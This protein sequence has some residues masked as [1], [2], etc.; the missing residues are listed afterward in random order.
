LPHLTRLS[1]VARR[2][3]VRPEI[4]GR[5]ARPAGPTDDADAQDASGSR[6]PGRWPGLPDRP[7]PFLLGYVKRRPLQFGVLFSIVVTATCC[8]VGAQYGMKLIVD[9]M[10]TGDRHSTM[11]W[12]W[13]ALFVG[14]IAVES[15]LWRLGGWL[16][17]RTVVGTGVDVRLDLFRHLS[18]HP[19]QYFANHMSGAL[20]SRVTATAGAVGGVFGS[21]TWHI[22]P[23]CI[24]FIGAIVVLFSINNRMALALVCSAAIVAGIITLFGGRGRPLH[25]AYAE[26]ASTV[27]GDLV[28]AVANM[29]TVKAFA[30]REREYQRL[31]RAFGIEAKAQRRSWLYTEKARVLHDL[32]LWLMAG[33]MLL[34]AIHG[35]RVGF[36][37]PGDV[38]VVSAL[39]FRILHGSRDLALSLVGVT[40]QTGVI[41]E[42]L[43][44][45]GGVHRVDDKPNAPPFVPRHGAVRLSDV[46]YGYDADRPVFRHFNLDIPAGQRVGVVGPSGAG[47]STL[48]GLIQ[49]LDDVQA[50]HIEIDGQRLTEVQQDSLREA[51][52]VV[53]QEIAL[54]H[55]S[56]LENIRYGRPDATIEEVHAAA[57]AA[58][59]DDFISCLPQG[60][61]T[62]VGERGVRLSGG[63]RQRIGIARAFLKDAPILLLDEATSSLDSASEQE[64]QLALSRLM[65]GRTVIAVAHRL[66]TVA[67]FDRVLV[68]VNGCV[69]EDGPPAALRCSGGL[70][71]KLWRLQAMGMETD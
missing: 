69:V 28:D 31:Q 12:R 53:P 29:W 61:E 27:A 42:M 16:G 3:Q 68:I 58:H 18:G 52:A 13:L 47:K 62:L 15:T 1:P 51:I 36:N 56:I 7:L 14:L 2:L 50:G 40:Q 35:W 33:G 64:I 11:I 44:T 41:G 39:T 24:D 49:R 71:E 43:R 23:P 22:I 55:R 57:R 25:Q 34:W 59:C 26:Q 38:V 32:C 4:S 60:Y 5:S 67:S 63:Q 54:F 65:H 37:S 17:C 70:Y 66:A 8:A 21:L 19:M 45:V 6:K 30:A 46:S 20:G 48:V 10:A 9:E